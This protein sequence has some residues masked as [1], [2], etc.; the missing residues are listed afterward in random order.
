MVRRMTEQGVNGASTD[1]PRIPTVEELVQRG[2]TLDDARIERTRAKARVRARRQ[3]E[4]ARA[5]SGAPQVVAP[6]TPPQTGTNER[7]ER[8]RAKARER[9]RLQRER[10]R[11]AEPA[12]EVGHIAPPPAPAERSDMQARVTHLEAKN[13]R[14]RRLL[15]EVIETLADD[16]DMARAA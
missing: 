5:E 6:A 16:E 14:L 15:C 9:A 10:Q 7:Q 11:A 8:V 1:E 12:A 4:Q 13:A 2:M 3:R